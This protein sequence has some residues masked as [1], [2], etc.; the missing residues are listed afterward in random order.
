MNY[1]QKKSIHQASEEF[2]V[3]RKSIINWIQNLP[4]L[5][6]S[7]N[8][9]K[10]FTIHSGKKAETDSIEAEIVEWI[11]MNRSLGVAAST[12]EVIKTI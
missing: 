10:K 8:K 5:I 2:G 6:A 4:E 12:W 9:S 1:A 7:K 11:L 3:E